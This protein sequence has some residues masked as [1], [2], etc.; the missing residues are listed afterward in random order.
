M[1]QL[2]AAASEATASA[3]APNPPDSPQLSAVLR[4]GVSSLADADLPL[5]SAA[6]S[7]TPP[8]PSPPSPTSASAS[9]STR[10]SSAHQRPSLAPPII[11]PDLAPSVRCWICY[12]DYL[13]DAGTPSATDRWVKPCKCK[14]S[15]GYV[16]EPCLLRFIASKENASGRP[17]CPQ[18]HTPYRIL[19]PASPALYALYK[20]DM[21]CAAAVPY[22]LLAGGGISVLF[23]STTYGVYALLSVAGEDAEAWLAD[24]EWGWRVW[25]GLP[26]VF[27][28]LVLA[29]TE[30]LDNILPLVPLW[31]LDFKH[32]TAPAALTSSLSVSSSS[33][34][35]LVA[36]WPPSPATAMVLLP[37]LR[38]AWNA[39][40]KQ[41]S[42]AVLLP[43]AL[44]PGPLSGTPS[45]SSA[46]ATSGDA[47]SPD[48]LAAR[49]EQARVDLRMSERTELGR[50]LVGAALVPAVASGVGY[51]LARTLPAGFA[52]KVAPTTLMRSLIGGC[53]FVVAKDL[54]YL[55]YRKQKLL[56]NKRKRVVNYVEQS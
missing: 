30:Y 39:M 54:T 27:P 44:H 40:Y 38:F 35:T 20:L 34:S 49:T 42:E 55:Y 51:L 12:T 41:L 6:N 1:D 36:W 8:S 28:V 4:S 25:A 32:I 22:F 48:A 14:G 17:A 21:A 37:W 50:L 24:P 16:H 29:R 52:A 11:P 45:L 47:E 23:L 53:V 33:P 9:I 10:K 19:S 3:T 15:L 18:C 56:V 5:S 13:D 31:L 46:T 2:R 26:L 7:P 43:I